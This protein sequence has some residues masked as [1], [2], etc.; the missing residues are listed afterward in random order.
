MSDRIMELL[1]NLRVEVARLDE[2]TVAGLRW[3]TTAEE[4]INNLTKIAI[5]STH[6]LQQHSKSIGAWEQTHTEM[7]I[8]KDAK[9]KRR[10]ALALFQWIAVLLTIVLAAAKVIPES[11]VKVIF[12]L[13]LGK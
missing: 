1:S 6:Q 9:E 10:Q 13:V 7:L 8:E 11:A 2:R 3:R 5:D 12:A 4:R